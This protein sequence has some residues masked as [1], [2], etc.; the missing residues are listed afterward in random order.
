MLH[1]KD[2]YGILEFDSTTDRGLCASPKYKSRVCNSPLSAN[3][4]YI[5]YSIRARLIAL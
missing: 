5:C 3:S 2:L 4:R 1:V